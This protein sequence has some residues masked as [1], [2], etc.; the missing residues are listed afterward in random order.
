MKKQANDKFYHLPVFLLKIGKIKMIASRIF[1]I[2]IFNY[3][4][5]ISNVTD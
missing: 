2:V 5:V 4:C 3:L 1:M